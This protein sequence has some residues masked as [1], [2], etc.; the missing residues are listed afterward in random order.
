MWVKTVEAYLKSEEAQRRALLQA[1]G[2][3]RG[4]AAVVHMTRLLARPNCAMGAI[5][6]TDLLASWD[7]AAGAG[8]GSTRRPSVAVLQHVL[9][10]R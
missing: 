4:A 1:A 3:E 5:L 10:C 7:V 2:K 6:R 8:V 9:W